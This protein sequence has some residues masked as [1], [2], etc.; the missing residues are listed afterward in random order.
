MDPI[1]IL[2]PKECVFV[3]LL[4]EKINTYVPTDDLYVALYGGE[5]GDWKKDSWEEN[6]PVFILY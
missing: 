6:I 4:I 2:R 1:I 3:K 5:A